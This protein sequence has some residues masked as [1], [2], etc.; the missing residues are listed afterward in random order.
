M[1]W[2]VSWDR[3]WEEYSCYSKEET[4]SVRDW[5]TAHLLA[6]YGQPW[7]YHGTCNGVRGMIFS[8]IKKV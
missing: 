5:A 7:N 8:E 6:F 3:E 1:G 4:G 2:G